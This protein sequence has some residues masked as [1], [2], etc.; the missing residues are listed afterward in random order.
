MHTNSNIQKIASFQASSDLSIK[1]LRFSKVFEVEYSKNSFSKYLNSKTQKT[2]F[3]HKKEHNSTAAITVGAT[4]RSRTQ[5]V[6][7]PEMYSLFSSSTFAYYTSSVCFF[8]K[9]ISSL[10][11]C[12]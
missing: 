4:V 8:S 3:L 9:N 11:C 2:A 10:R 5:A 6:R 7:L 1:K 12:S